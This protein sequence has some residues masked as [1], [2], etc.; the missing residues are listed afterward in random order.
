MGSEVRKR[1]LTTGFE[2]L[3]LIDGNPDAKPLMLLHAKR[4]II[5]K[6]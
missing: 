5:R 1:W 2:V 4:G 6:L 3:C